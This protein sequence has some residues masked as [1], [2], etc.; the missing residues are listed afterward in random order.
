[1][2][3]HQ[4]TFGLEEFLR[5]KKLLIQNAETDGLKKTNKKKTNRHFKTLV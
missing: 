5:Q 3:T 4:T 1:M 2:A